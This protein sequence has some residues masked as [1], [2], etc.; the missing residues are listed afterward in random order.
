M[1]GTHHRAQVVN[2]FRHVGSPIGNIDLLYALA[3]LSKAP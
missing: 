3:E 2:M 1:H